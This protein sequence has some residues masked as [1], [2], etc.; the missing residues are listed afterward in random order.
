MMVEMRNI[1]GRGISN[2]HEFEVPGD[3]LRLYLLAV[4]RLSILLVNLRAVDD[5]E[6]SSTRHFYEWCH[7]TGQLL[8]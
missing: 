3:V 7:C 6:V 5:I 4:G 1:S 2:L 8:L